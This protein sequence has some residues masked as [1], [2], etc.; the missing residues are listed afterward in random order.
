MSRLSLLARLSIHPA[1]AIGQ[2]LHLAGVNPAAAAAATAA[3][4]LAVA[5]AVNDRHLVSQCELNGGGFT[6]CT[7]K[8]IG[9]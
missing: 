1:Y 5:V 4:A 7:L 8:I 3:A 6:V 2:R 9:R